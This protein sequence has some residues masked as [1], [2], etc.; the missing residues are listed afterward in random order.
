LV[1]TTIDLTAP[2]QTQRLAQGYNKM[3]NPTDSPMPGWPGLGGGGQLYST[4]DDMMKFLSFNMGLTE[5]PLNSVLPDLQKSWRPIT[6]KPRKFQGLGWQIVERKTRTLWKNGGTPGFRSYIGFCKSKKS[7]VFVLS[8]SLQLSP[9]D[10]GK[11]L[12]G[13]LTGDPLPSAGTP[14]E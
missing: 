4:P 6:G 3:G 12:L 5:T 8:N 14:D 9:T 7:G 2:Q 11:D 1:D 13:F 10:L